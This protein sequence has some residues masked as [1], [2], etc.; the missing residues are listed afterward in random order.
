MVAVLVDQALAVAEQD[1]P[2]AAGARRGT[3]RRSRCAA[4]GAALWISMPSRP[5][6]S[7]PA[8]AA[9]SRT[10]SSRPTRIAVPRP[11]LTKETAARITCSSSPSAKTTRFG[12][13]RTRSK[14]RLQRAGDR[15]AP[16]REL[17][18]VG[19][20]VDDR[21]A[22]DAGVHRRLGDR[23]RH[24]VD[25]AR[26]ERHRD[27]VVAPEARPRALIGGGDLVRHVLAGERGERLRRGDLHLHVDRRGAHVERAAEDVGEAEDVVDLVR[28][29]RAAGRDD[30]VV[31]DC[32]R[33]PPA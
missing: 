31:A 26:I 13:L 4:T 21:P 19:A 10:R 14:M 25:Q 16:R 9:V 5:S 12:N 3:A 22:R 30:D 15:I 6:R 29:V 18:L 32:G 28:I 1:S 8:T 17:R 7:M 2:C 11:W 23:R 24:R 33:P 27:D 20:H